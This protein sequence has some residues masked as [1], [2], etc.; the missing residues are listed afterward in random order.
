MTATSSLL[1]GWSGERTGT[2]LPIYNGGGKFLLHAEV[3]PTPYQ[4]MQLNLDLRAG[5]VSCP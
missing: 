3:G 5:S 2:I 4:L 1:R